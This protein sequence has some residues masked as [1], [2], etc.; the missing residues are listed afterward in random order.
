MPTGERSS[1]LEVVVTG[2]DGTDA[3]IQFPSKEVIR[4][5]IKKLPDGIS[6]GSRVRLAVATNE[7]EEVARKELAKEV[8]NNLLQG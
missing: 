8:L 6:D 5:P 3:L 4:W 2:F 7:S 1:Y